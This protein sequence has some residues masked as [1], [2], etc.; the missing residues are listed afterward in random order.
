REAEGRH[1]VEL[2]A[3]DG[4][5]PRRAPRAEIEISLLG[6]LALERRHGFVE[7]QQQRRTLAADDEMTRA[8][9]GNE[10]A[11]RLI[12]APARRRAG[13]RRRK[14]DAEQHPE[15]QAPLGQFDRA[16]G[17]AHGEGASTI[18]TP[19]D[20]AA[21]MGERQADA[22]PRQIA[23]QEPGSIAYREAGERS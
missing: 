11:R 10:V 16:P 21:G 6:E 7:G 22:R 9:A 4:D 18:V 15:A 14:L 5:R 1:L 13:D 8:D 23:S 20:L 12:A 3:Q 19:G 17:A 2:V